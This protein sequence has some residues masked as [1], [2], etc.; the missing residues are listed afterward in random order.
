MT[1][2][3][4]RAAPVLA[5]CRLPMHGCCTRAATHVCD[6]ACAVC[7]IS[8]VAPIGSVLGPPGRAACG[9]CHASSLELRCRRRYVYS[10]LGIKGPCA[11]LH[12]GNQ[13]NCASI[14]RESK[15]QCGGY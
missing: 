4:C 5:G 13:L 12:S 3:S 15:T 2:T 7:G 1:C 11:R 6:A 14:Q 9:G 8:L 10:T